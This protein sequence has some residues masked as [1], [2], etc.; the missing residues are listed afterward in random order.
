VACVRATNTIAKETMKPKLVLAA[1]TAAAIIPAAIPLAIRAQPAPTQI[2]PEDVPAG[3][4]VIDTKETLVRY[5]TSHMG[6]TEFWGT[7]PG[8]TGTMT[9]DPKALSATKLEVTVPVVGLETTNRELNGEFFSDEFFDGEKFRAMKF[10]STDVTRTG[11]T[12]ARVTGN[13]TIHGVT[14][15][16]VLNVTF[17]GGGHN[18]LKKQVLT[19]GFNAEGVVKRSDFGLGKYVPLVSDETK[20]FISAAWELQK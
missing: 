15:P 12:T 11:P 3:T 16:A 20:I 4:Y 1:V 9:L 7:F 6:W 2:G 19:I 5:S 17:N 13:L 8:A 10:V 14:R 18:T